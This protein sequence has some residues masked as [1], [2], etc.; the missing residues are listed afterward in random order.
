MQQRAANPG[1]FVRTQIKAGIDGEPTN[2][3]FLL[4]AVC[5]WLLARWHLLARR[6][7]LGPGAPAAPGRCGDL[8]T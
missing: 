1:F 6:R 7:R 4:A 8:F 5:W 2:G 3:A